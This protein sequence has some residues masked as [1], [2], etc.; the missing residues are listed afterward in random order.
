MRFSH[1]GDIDL[2]LRSIPVVFLDNADIIPDYHHIKVCKNPPT[3]K[4]VIKKYVKY[5]ITL[6]LWAD[7]YTM[8]YG[9]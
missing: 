8:S 6:K 5:V 9:V 1:F 3:F 7:C 2:H 4:E